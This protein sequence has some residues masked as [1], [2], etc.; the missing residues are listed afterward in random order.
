MTEPKR[1]ASAESTAV[2]SPQVSQHKA[3]WSWI[4]DNAAAL[5]LVLAAAIALVGITNHIVGKIGEVKLDNANIAS[6]LKEEIHSASQDL[7]NEINENSKQIEVIEERIT[8]IKE[9]I[10]EIKDRIPLP[11]SVYAK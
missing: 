1:S 10:K 2:A 7:K 6:D 5:G 11:V 4:K 8:G 3:I 9:D